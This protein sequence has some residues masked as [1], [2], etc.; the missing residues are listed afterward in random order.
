[1]GKQDG[2]NYRTQHCHTLSTLRADFRKQRASTF[3]F[4]CANNLELIYEYVP[5]ECWNLLCFCP[6][7]NSISHSLN[8]W[9]SAPL[10]WLHS[11]QCRQPGAYPYPRKWL[12]H[13]PHLVTVNNITPQGCYQN[14]LRILCPFNSCHLI[15]FILIRTAKLPVLTLI[16]CE[17]TTP[18]VMN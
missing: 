14:I 4:F 13:A 11:K 10:K 1:M 12:Q 18:S 9:K 17:R 2:K 8:W 3:L 7:L 16:R 5:L 6:N 15:F